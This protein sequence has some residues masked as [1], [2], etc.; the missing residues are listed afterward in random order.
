MGVVHGHAIT[1]SVEMHR[2]RIGI[3]TGAYFGRTRSCLVLKGAG[4]RPI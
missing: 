4:R 2:N 1:P 3:D